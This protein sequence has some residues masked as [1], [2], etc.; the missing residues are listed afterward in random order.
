MGIINFKNQL[1]Y[2]TKKQLKIIG[3]IVELREFGKEF[4]IGDRPKVHKEKLFGDDEQNKKEENEYTPEEIQEMRYR[5]AKRSVFDY[6]NCNSFAWPDETGHVDPPIFITF[7]FREDIQDIKKANHEFTKFMQRFNFFVTGKKKSYLKY[8]VVIEFQKKT[9]DTIHYHALYFNLPYI[10]GIKT[11]LE[12]TWGQGFVKV[13]AT[14]RIKNLTRYMTKYMTKDL[15]DPRLH[16]KKSYFVSR[17]LKK[18]V[19]VYYDE[20]IGEFLKYLPKDAIEFETKDFPAG[21]METMDFVRYNMNEFP[22]DLKNAIDFLQ[23]TGYDGPGYSAPQQINIT[24]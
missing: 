7:T 19:L 22:K 10:R 17:G 13:V 24:P 11:K 4:F 23:S 15:N 8:L 20:L 9:R 12:N 14:K 2:V 16:G 6:V 3:P 18:P 1:Y 5:R 21:Y